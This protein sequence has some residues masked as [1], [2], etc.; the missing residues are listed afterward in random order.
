M[1]PVIIAGAGP[2]GLALSLGLARHGVP[3]LLLDDGGTPRPQQ[4]ERTVV[5]R[6]ESAELLARLG[7]RAVHTDGLRWTA[8]RTVRRRQ[9]VQRVEFGDAPGGEPAPLH[10]SQDR[11]LRGLREAIA[12]QELIRIMR[13]SRVDALEQDD[14]GVSVHTR[15][16]ETDAETWWRGSFLVGCDGARSTV[17]KLLR[18][19]FP[20]RTAVDRFAVAA[21]RVS[22]PEPDAALLHREPPGGQRAGEVI[23]R[24]LPDRVWR[25]D[26]TLPRSRAPLT[27]DAL[28][29]LIRRALATWCQG[30]VPP[31]DL[32]G[33]A[34]YA[35][36][37]RLARHFRVGRSFLAG[38]AAH[39]LGALGTQGVEE[40][41]RDADN[42]AWKLAHAWHDSASDILLDSYQ[43]ERRTA[44]GARLRAAD[45]ALPLLRAAGAW[46]TVRQTLLSGPMSRHTE[47]LTD[48][49]LGHGLLGGPPVYD[50]SPLAP[51]PESGGRGSATP[52]SPAALPRGAMVEDTAVTA[53]DGT[54]GRLRDRLGQAL[55]V[56]LVAP[57]TG[58]WE[59][60]H[61][62]TAGLMPQ[63][64]AAVAAL[65]M[66]AELLVAESYPGALAHTVLVVRPD[67]HLVGSMTGCRPPELYALADALRGG[68]AQG[69]LDDGSHPSDGG[70]T[71]SGGP[72]SPGADEDA[73]APVSSR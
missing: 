43:A 46:H 52:A 32:L 24:P 6:P 56:V 68:P 19:R 20:G 39:L 4:P 42:L 60:R 44:V 57:G 30:S 48:G 64:S 16:V 9:E 29:A 2:T 69:R 34:E 28:V 8:W 14:H 36:H 11:L 1:E 38:D 67:G 47:L 61:W 71:G 73:D 62:L 63:L 22:L 70:P 5:L 7:Y 37:Q 13:G 45:Q 21:L 49:H 51:A 35:V 26:W 41:L 55:L 23:A 25:I 31:Y 18:V 66:R 27:S 72:D 33:S 40:G 17:R 59:S 15:N 58:V 65:P 54:Q 10:L 3:V 53:M 50:R 12:G